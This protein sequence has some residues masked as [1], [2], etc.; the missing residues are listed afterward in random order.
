VEV[1]TPS[2]QMDLDQEIQVINPKDK[3]VIP[4]ERPK[5]RIPELPPVPK[6]YPAPLK[7]LLRVQK[8]K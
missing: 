3:N 8:L 4:E 6:G 7:L 5:W 2:N 1:T